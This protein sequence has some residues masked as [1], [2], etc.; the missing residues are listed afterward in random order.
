MLFDLFRNEFFCYSGHFGQNVSYFDGYEPKAKPTEWVEW[1]FAPYQSPNET[2]K[3]LA[4]PYH[5]YVTVNRNAKGSLFDI[6]G[7]L[8][9]LFVETALFTNM[10]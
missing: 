2:F 8:F 6:S 5:P 4:S 9:T 10:R 7:P 1:M 3:F